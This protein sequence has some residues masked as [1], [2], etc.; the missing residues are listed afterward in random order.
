MIDLYTK[1]RLLIDGVEDFDL[2]KK[3]VACIR[4]LHDVLDLCREIEAERYGSK[5]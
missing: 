5:E 1:E 3:Q 4:T 2:Y